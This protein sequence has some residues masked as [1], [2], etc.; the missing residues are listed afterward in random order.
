MDLEQFLQERQQEVIDSWL[1]ATF[2]LFSDESFRYLKRKKNDFFQNPLSFTLAEGLTS[3]F[4]V[5]LEGTD[6]KKLA[7]PLEQVIKIT[8]IQ[9]GTPSGALTFVFLLKKVVRKM[10]K[11]TEDY[12][13]MKEELLGFDH[14]V[15]QLIRMSFDIYAKAREEIY[16]LK[17]DE[18][19]IQTHNV[20]KL[21]NQQNTKQQPTG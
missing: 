14:V 4:T 5:L 19:K 7:P 9:E 16:Q 18:Q 2:R 1:E 12:E 17:V 8:S 15:D 3:L 6:P 21:A 13:A 10:V 20:I 11:E